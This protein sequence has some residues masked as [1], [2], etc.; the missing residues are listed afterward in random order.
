VT[1]PVPQ[2]HEIKHK[3]IA[4]YVLIFIFVDRKVKIKD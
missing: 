2:P 3:T 4:M 1:D